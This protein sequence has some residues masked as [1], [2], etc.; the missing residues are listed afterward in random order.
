MITRAKIHSFNKNGQALLII[1]SLQKDI[2]KPLFVESSRISYPGFNVNYKIGD[3]VLVGFED[4]DMGKPI[5]LGYLE[6]ASDESEKISL[7]VQ[8]LNVKGKLTTN[9]IENQAIIENPSSIAR[10]PQ[11][12]EINNLVKFSDVGKLADSGKSIEDILETINNNLGVRGSLSIYSNNWNNN[13]YSKDVLSLD[14]GDL[15]LDGKG[16]ILL[17][18][19]TNTD[20]T[21]IQNADI[22]THISNNKLIFTAVTTPTNNITFDY[23]ILK[24]R[25][26]L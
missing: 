25:E 9:I 17:T 15:L 22:F 4:N 7:E 11:E 2:S 14:G 16:A 18:P 1:A 26:N 13:T 12:F 10:I 20:K 5:I 3:T 24:E 8:D 21:N 23:F 6:S 19:Q